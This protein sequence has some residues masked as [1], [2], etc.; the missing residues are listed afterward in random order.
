MAEWQYR[1]VTLRETQERD[2][3]LDVQPLFESLQD[4]GWEY[5]SGPTVGVRALGHMSYVFLIRRPQ[6]SGRILM[7]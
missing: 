1:T 2:I 7:E 3:D 5:V 6:H 4:D